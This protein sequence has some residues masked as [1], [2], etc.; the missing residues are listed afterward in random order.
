MAWRAR[1]GPGP[2]SSPASSTRT[3]FVELAGAQAMRGG[4]NAIGAKAECS[5]SR[6]SHP[7][8][9]GGLTSEVHV[10][11]AL[12]EQPAAPGRSRPRD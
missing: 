8:I 7:L 4:V 12:G 11:D 6:G 2:W 5:T 1:H 3:G 9:E 10:D